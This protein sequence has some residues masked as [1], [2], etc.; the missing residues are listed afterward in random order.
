[1]RLRIGL[2]AIAAVT[3]TAAMLTSGALSAGGPD[4]RTGDKLLGAC[5]AEKGEATSWCRAYLIGA[6]DMLYM[7]GTGGHSTGICGAAYT[8]E[9]LEDAYISWMEEHPAM[10]NVD[11]AVGASLAFRN[12]WPCE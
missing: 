6:A 9:I 4:Q 11:M 12:R 5:E 8:P 7:I 3:L 2:T 10:E 1:M